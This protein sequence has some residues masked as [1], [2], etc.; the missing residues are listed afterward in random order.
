M[1]K[2]KEYTFIYSSPSIEPFQEL[3][4]EILLLSN[5]R[6]SVND[7]F[8]YGVFCKEETYANYEHWDEAPESL[9]IPYELTNPCSVPRDRVN[10]VHNII[11]EII[12]GEIDKPSWMI[13]VEMED[14]CNQ[15]EQAPSTFLYISVKDKKYEVLAGKL[16]D[17]LY[18][19]NLITTLAYA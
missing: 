12:R 14:V 6:L 13:Y 15:Y 18:S 10:Y 11:D 5:T 1:I 17:F 8:D 3:V 16:L 2:N 4:N 19:P 9:D 7:I